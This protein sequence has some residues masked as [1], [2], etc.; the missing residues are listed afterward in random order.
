[1]RLSLCTSN[2]ELGSDMRLPRSELRLSRRNCSNLRLQLRLLCLHRSETATQLQQL[3]LYCCVRGLI[4]RHH[5]ERPRR[6]VTLHVRALA[7]GL[8][9]GRHNSHALG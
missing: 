8:A 9:L 1:M 2:T 3:F 7:A 6:C 5:R 4:P